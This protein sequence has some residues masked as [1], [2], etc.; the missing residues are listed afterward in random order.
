MNHHS[1]SYVLYL[2]AQGLAEASL[3][4]YHVKSRGE[5]DVY[6]ISSVESILIDVQTAL[7]AVKEI[8]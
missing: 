1:E 2:K 3:N 4:L 8:K 6:Y 7:A 5:R